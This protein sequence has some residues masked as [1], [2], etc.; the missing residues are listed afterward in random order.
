[1]LYVHKYSANMGL[2]STLIIST[3]YFYLAT[4]MI[5]VQH[6]SRGLPEPLI[7]LTYVGLIMFIVG[8]IG[9]FY[10]HNL[11]SKLRT[12]N[13][14]EYKIPRGGLFNL[15]ICPHYLFEIMMFYGFA[16]ISQ[17]SMAFACALSVSCYLISRGHQT[18]KWYANKF[19]DFP[20]S[21]KCVI[22]YVF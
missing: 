7:D 13:K 17:T 19:E 16:F 6:L 5:V 8:I 20:T 18:R 9:N 12:N 22:P 15:V 1:V 21:I 10:H 11:L 3:S 14:K 4:S 2:G